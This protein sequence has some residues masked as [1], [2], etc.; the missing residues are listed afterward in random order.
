M[1]TQ[2]KEIIF[3]E[4]A[5]GKLKKGIDTLADVVAITL[6][7]KGRNVGL[8]S[9]WGPP[10]ITNDGKSIIDGIEL[11]DT[12]SNI[13]I[14]LAKEMANKIKEESGDGSTTGILLLRSLVQNGM[15]NITS[16]TSPILLKKGMDK[17]L[18]KLLKEL[19]KMACPIQEDKEIQNTA[20]VSASGNEEVG[21]VICEGLKKVG[22]N[23]V[24]LIEEGKKT[25]TLLE[26]VEGM[27]LDRGYISPYFATNAETL[28]TEM[29]HPLILIT[30]KKISGIQEILPIL[31]EIATTGKELCILAEDIEG[32]ALSTLVV[33]KLKGTLKVSAI[34][35]PGFGDN[36]KSLLEDIA[37]LTG[38]AVLT[39]ETGINLREATIDLLGSAEKIILTKDQ[40][41]IIQGKGNKQEI[42]DRVLQIKEEM[43][44]ATGSYDKEKLQER[45]AKLQ[46][47]VAV[48][49]V[50]AQTEP[51][52]KQ[53]KQLFQDSLHSTKAALE[54]GIV[55]GGGIALLRAAHT[56]GKLKLEKE[57]AVGADILLQACY[58]PFKQIVAN[59]G[60]D[61]SLLLDKILSSKKGAIGFNV[62]TET[63]EDLLV[64]GV[65]DATK[66]VKNSLLHAVSMAGL[67]LLSEALIVNAK[68]EEN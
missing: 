33:N 26:I 4:N 5:R 41:T 54:Q 3:E 22:K 1:S 68:E 42:Y 15:K 40:T 29:L 8:Q 46:G 45:L 32:D 47:G 61:S 36:R 30:D 16:G 49:R 53:K 6:G 11:K 58:A 39:E 23:G 52:M 55:P 7:P 66:V 44:Q 17:A 25:E 20:T 9:P 56:L 12:F 63:I 38:A 64:A 57:E 67:V 37:T 34:K 35:A 43:K 10:K 13:G 19:D 65:V 59:A 50:G 62:M 31:Q 21:A 14:Q 24:I 60:Q 27:Q 48:I 18:E 2:P 51:E 28:Q